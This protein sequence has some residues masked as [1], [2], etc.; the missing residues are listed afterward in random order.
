MGTRADWSRSREK[1]VEFV[2]VLISIRHLNIPRVQRGGV[3]ETFV[4]PLRVA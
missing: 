1:R 2:F 4:R 3:I